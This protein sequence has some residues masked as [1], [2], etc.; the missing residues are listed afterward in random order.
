MRKYFTFIT[1]LFLLSF[2]NLLHSQDIS[3]EELYNKIKDNYTTIYPK[4]FDAYIEGKIVEAQISTIPAKNYLSSKDKIRLK[5]TLVQNSKP[6]IV[7]ENVDSF[8]AK[9]FSVFEEPL[10]TVGFYAIVSESYSS[11]S[12]KF[13][14]DSIKEDNDKYEVVLR[15]VGENK[16]YSINYT[17]NKNSLLVESADYYNKK[18]K[19]YDVDISYTNIDNYT[20]PEIIKYKSS[21]GKVNSQIQFVDIK[22]SSK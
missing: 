20:V 10:E 15:A 18:S 2:F 19:I 16:D 7:L 8:Y 21:D 22:V 1:L 11:L 9:M 3:F 13:T 17:I 12:K 4:R 6:N 5:F 14:V